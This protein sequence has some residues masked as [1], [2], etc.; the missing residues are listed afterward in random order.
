MSSSIEGERLPTGMIR[1]FGYDEHGT[2]FSL[3]L[4][5]LALARGCDQMAI[6][7][8]LA[9]AGRRHRDERPLFDESETL[10]EPERT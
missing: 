8:A 10:R 2:S 1:V 7:A 6:Q 4:D 5:P 9:L 3:Y